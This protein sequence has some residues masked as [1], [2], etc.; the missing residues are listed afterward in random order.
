MASSYQGPA[1]KVGMTSGGSAGTDSS[2]ISG[3]DEVEVC[4]QVKELFTRSK[5]RLTRR[6]ERWR[7]NYRLIHNRSWAQGRGSVMPSPTASEAFPI[8]S[9]LVGW[10]TDQRTQFE[11]VAAVDPGSD[12]ADF[13]QGLANELGKCL[14]REIGKKSSSKHRPTSN[15]L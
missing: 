3:L 8:L 9:S 1:A 7:R 10:M 14:E 5:E 2:L 4:F 12:Y 11:T 15:S 13:M 6:H